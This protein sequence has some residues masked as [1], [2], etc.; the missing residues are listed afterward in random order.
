MAAFAWLELSSLT[1]EIYILAMACVTLLAEVTLPATDRLSIGTLVVLALLGGLY[2]NYQTLDFGPRELFAG[3]FVT[4]TFTQRIKILLIGLM[5]V[6]FVHTLGSLRRLKLFGGEYYSLLLFSLLGMMV[7]TS[8]A[9]LLGVYLGLEMVALPMYA[10]VGLDRNNVYAPEAAMKYF[11]LGGLASGLML[12]GMSLLFGATSTLSLASLHSVISIEGGSLYL[13]FA[14][15]FMLVGV[16]FKFGA[17]PFHLW[18]P[19]VYHGASNPVVV[20]L[21]SVPKIAAFVLFAR[22]IHQG[23]GSLIQDWQGLVMACG[24]ASIVLGNVVAIWQTDIRRLL[25]YSAIAHVGFVLMALS[26]GAVG[27]LAALFYVFTYAFMSLGAFALV[28]VIAGDKESHYKLE[29]FSGLGSTQ[30]GLA[31]ALLLILFSMA[32]IPPLLGFY[33]KFMVIEAVVKA[34]FTWVAV[35][36]VLFSIVGAFYYLRIIRLMYFEKPVIAVGEVMPVGERWL[37]ATHAWGLLL[38]GC[39]PAIPFGWCAAVF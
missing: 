8:S 36:M 39:F 10:L 14:L 28:G 17:F 38:F 32:G 23:L 30:P 5:L 22:L 18:V 9:S 15:V 24:L 13:Q 1:P 4:D 31:F 11:I 25:G 27:K 7:L 33:G 21:A 29:A 19:D 12:Y 20:V 2:L 26:L 35:P 3:E 37:A 16:L 6:A 34:G